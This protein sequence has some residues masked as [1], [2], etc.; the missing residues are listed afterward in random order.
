MRVV[1]GCLKCARAM[2]EQD[3]WEFIDFNTHDHNRYMVFCPH[4]E[5]LCGG[6][7][8]ME[9]IPEE[10]PKPGSTDPTQD[11]HG[12]CEAEISSTD[13]VVMWYCTRESGH[14]MPHVAG[15]GA[16]VAAVW[17]DGERFYDDV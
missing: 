11:E 9:D 13:D 5:D 12:N 10:W 16:E 6:C 14:P 1:L 15:T 8:D 4:E 7:G 2:G 17:D 3:G